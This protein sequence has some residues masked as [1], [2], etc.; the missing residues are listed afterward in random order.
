MK[1]SRIFDVIIIGGSYSGLASAMALGRARKDVLV[2]DS[3]MPCNRQTPYSHNFL[4]Q[5]GKAPGIIAAIG[6][7]Q[8]LQYNTV[9]FVNG[10]AE[11]GNRT[12]DSFEIQL[13]SGETFEG[14]KLI[15][16]TGIHDT[17]PEIEGLPE[18]WGISV[19]H[20]PYCHGYEVKDEKTGILGNGDQGFEMTRL[21]SNWTQDLTL[22]TNGPSKLSVEQKAKLDH[23]QIHIVEKEIKELSHE[24][25][26]IHHILF[27]DN[28]STPIK[29]LYAKAHFEQHSKIPESLGCELTDEGYLKIDALF[30]TTVKGVYACGD[31]VSPT[32]TV[33]NAVAMGT[34]TGIS[35]SKK[36]IFENF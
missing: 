23:Y 12:D 13:V 8:V 1:T 9:T 25:G 28:T 16:A 6:R 5:D 19:L 22:Y 20:C 33:A 7:E 3:G 14:R 15:F 10:F 2:I 21:I 32:R 36:I 18:S 26:Y 35:V 4:T 11:K 30:E 27:K 24:N 29:A 17:L 34:A 31:N